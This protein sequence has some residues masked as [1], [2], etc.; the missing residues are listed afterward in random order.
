V[1]QRFDEDGDVAIADAVRSIA[2]IGEERVAGG[3]AFGLASHDMDSVAP[4]RRGVVDGL[5]D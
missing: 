1:I 2:Q 5:V 4:R 3:G